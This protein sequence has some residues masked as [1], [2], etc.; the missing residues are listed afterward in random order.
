MKLINR[1]KYMLAVLNGDE[2]DI[3]QHRRMLMIRHA[4]QIVDYLEDSPVTAEDTRKA[5]YHVSMLER[6]MK[7][8]HTLQLATRYS[9]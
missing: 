3:N 6:H 9:T 2:D 7:M 4:E 1:L 5:L 8:L